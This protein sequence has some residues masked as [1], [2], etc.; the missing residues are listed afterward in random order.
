MFSKKT[1][2]PSLFKAL[3]VEYENRIAFGEVSASN[4]KLCD[5]FNVESF[6]TVVLV[7]SDGNAEDFIPYKGRF[8]LIYIGNF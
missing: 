5:K 1:A 7:K 6:P 4:T 8:I 3:S 2:T